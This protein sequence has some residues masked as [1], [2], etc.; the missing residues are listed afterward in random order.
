MTLDAIG[1][2]YICDTN[3]HRTQ[4]Y[5][6]D[7]TSGTTVAGIK[8]GAYGSLP[9]DLHFPSSILLDSSNNIYVAD[10]SNNRIQFWAPNAPNGTTILSGNTS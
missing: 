9:V 3:N 2:L 5:L 1:S 4:K 10:T 6:K 8:S 7:G